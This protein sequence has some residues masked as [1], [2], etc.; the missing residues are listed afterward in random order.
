[1]TPTSTDDE[2]GEF[3]A[4]RTQRLR[5]FAYICCGDWYRAED[6]VQTALVRLYLVWGRPKHAVDAYVRRII[7][8]LLITERKRLR[9]SRERVSDELPEPPGPDTAAMATDRV[10]VVGAMLRLPARQRAAIALRYWEDLPVEQAAHVLGCST[11]AVKNLT[12]RGIQGLRAHLS[13]SDLADIEGVT[14]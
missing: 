5:Q 2:F 13:E 3:V 7:V 6:V 11:G 8:N 1:M 9:F 10:T 4:S 14:R 12:M